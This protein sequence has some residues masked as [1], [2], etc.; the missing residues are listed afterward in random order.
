MNHKSIAINLMILLFIALSIIFAI[1]G[2]YA[3][4]VLIQIPE[5]EEELSTNFTANIYW[6]FLIGTI[7]WLGCSFLMIM[8]AYGIYK[9]TRWVWTAAMILNTLAI[10]VFAIMLAAFMVTV[11]TFQ[12]FFS[13]MGIVTSVLALLI[14]FCIVYLLTRPNIKRY[15]ISS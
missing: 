11:L 14:D 13:T 6:V 2:K 12:D 9:K 10:I 3:A 5:W 15:L 7:V 8:I 1:W 4:E